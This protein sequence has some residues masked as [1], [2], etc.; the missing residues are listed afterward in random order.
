MKASHIALL[1]G[2]NVGGKNRL[3]MKD[4]AALFEA[5][6]C[7]EVRTFIQSGN[8]VFGASEAVAAK[9]PAQVSAAILKAHGLRVPVVLRTADELLRVGRRNPFLKGG[10]VLDTLHVAF[11]ADAPSA[12]AASALDPK[13][14]PPDEIAIRGRELYLRLPNG[15]SATKITNDYLDRTLGTVSTMRSWRTTTQL[16]ELCKV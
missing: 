3:P 10:V 1:R 7:V 16:I 15:V 2:I 6:G 4:L 9:L 5:Q 13:R 14:S 11:L 8:V 12:S